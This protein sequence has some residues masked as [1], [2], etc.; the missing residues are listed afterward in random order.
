M[1]LDV[2]SYVVH[3]ATQPRRSERY[4]DTA[5]LIRPSGVWVR[6]GALVPTDTQNI[7]ASGRN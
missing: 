2:S 7:R 1:A 6:T 5:C 3:A 4:Q